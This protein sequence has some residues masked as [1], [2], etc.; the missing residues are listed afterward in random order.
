LHLVGYVHNYITMHGFM[1]VKFKQTR[2]VIY[3][4]RVHVTFV[5]VERQKILH[6][7]CVCSIRYPACTAHGAYGHLWPEWLYHISH[8]LIE[9]K[10]F[11]KPLLNV[12]CF[13]SI[14]FV[15]NI[16]HYEK[17]WARYDHKCILIFMWSTLYVKRS[18][19]EGLFMWS[20]LYVKRSLC[21]ALFMWSTLYVKRSLCEALFMWSTLYVKHSLFSSDFNETWI[22]LTDFEKIIK[23]QISRKS[24]LWE[25]RSSRQTDRRTDRHDKANSCSLEF[26]ERA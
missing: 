14:T 24:V 9:D 11:G 17:K 26:C 22:L 5:A 1:N 18:L 23:Y 21:E 8:Y 16:F 25:T 12:K 3:V 15:R 7:P 2:Q 20:A 10:I 4:R 13:F 6:I 19:Y